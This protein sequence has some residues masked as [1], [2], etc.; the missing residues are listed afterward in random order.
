MHRRLATLLL[1]A[2]GLLALS[3]LPAAGQAAGTRALAAGEAGLSAAPAAGASVDSEGAFALA[4]APGEF[5]SQL[6]VVANET[7]DRRLTIRIVPVDGA[8]GSD[9]V[10]YSSE[11]TEQGSGSWLAPTV[12]VVNVE[13]GTFAEV[14]FTVEVPPDA[15]PGDSADAAL[16]VFVESAADLNGAP[17]PFDDI[18]TLHVPVTIAVP[19][20]PEPRLAV[21]SVVAAEKGGSPHLAVTVRNAGSVVT[22]ASGTVK[23]PGGQLSRDMHVRVEPR[24]E[25]TILVEWEAIDIVHG[26]E[27]AVELEYG[28]GDIATWVGVVPADPENE[29]VPPASTEAD[30][31]TEPAPANAAPG[32]VAPASGNDSGA[33]TLI[34]IAI[35]VMLVGAAVW[36]VVEL[37]GGRKPASVPIDPAAFPNLRVTMDPRHTDV[38]D[39]LVTQVGALG[40]AIGTLADKVGV[41]V[42][43]PVPPPTIGTTPGRKHRDPARPRHAPNEPAVVPISQRMSQRMATATGGMFVPPPPAHDVLPTPS[44]QEIAEAIGSATEKMN[45]PPILVPPPMPDDWLAD[46]WSAGGGPPRPPAKTPAPRRFLK[47][48]P[49]PPPPDLAEWLGPDD[50]A[51]EAFF[52]DAGGDDEFWPDAPIDDAS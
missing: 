45:R 47:R 8:R 3:A 22:E 21:T 32:A 14:P 20:A 38:L 41:T 28:T 33:G 44:R 31:E 52:A 49:P 48:P 27:V 17:A 1:G 37:V 46:E 2:A 18:A 29:T 7:D 42:A 34:G 40:G 24:K 15:A 6:L 4:I 5:V 36:F 30:G 50:A 23:A 43:I 25:K 9:G 13:P 12:G 35:L 11:A 16:R 39:A 10:T 51:V 26:A 19:G